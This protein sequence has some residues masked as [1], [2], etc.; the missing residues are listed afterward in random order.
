MRRGDCFLT[1][2]HKP[3]V[4]WDGPFVIEEGWVRDPVKRRLRCVSDARVVASAATHFH[5]RFIL[6][7]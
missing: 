2:Y 1:V 7:Q 3:L 5:S 4:S 6:D